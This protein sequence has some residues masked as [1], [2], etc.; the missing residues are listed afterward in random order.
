MFLEFAAHASVAAGFTAF[1]K[2]EEISTL[3]TRYWDRLRNGAQ[4]VVVLGPGGVGKTTLGK[5]V[6]DPT[7]KVLPLP[8]NESFGI[9]KVSLPGIASAQIMAAPGQERRL[10]ASWDE[11]ALE[12]TKH[13]RVGII[14]IVANGYHSTVLSLKDIRK[15]METSSQ[16]KSRF[17]HDC[18]EKEL[19]QLRDIESKLKK[20]NKPLWMITLVTKQDLW[21]ADK[22]NVK[23]HYESG[24]Y[25]DILKRISDQHAA[26]GFKHEFFSISFH[27][28][29]LSVAGGEAIVETAKGYDDAMKYSHQYR[30]VELITKFAGG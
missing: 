10:D 3:A 25:G 30:F 23:K 22:E 15:D 11:V 1:E 14:N 2:R 24:E 6:E 9:E 27:S 7:T 26:T 13:K 21:W 28:Q 12:L 8:Y 5:F 29:N 16:T 18:R 19:N 20:F 4:I 17:F